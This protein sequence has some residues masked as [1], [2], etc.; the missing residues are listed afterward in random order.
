MD[1]KDRG[2]PSAPPASPRR[3]DGAR[4]PEE[5]RQRILDAARAEFSGKGLGGA[6]VNAIAERAGVN[7]QLIYYYYD[8]KERLFG[9]VLEEAYREIRAR[10]SALDL[11][12]LSPEDAMRRFIGFNFDFLVE[13]RSFVA[14]LNDENL[15]KARH[16][17]AS[18][19]ILALHE[20]LG[21]TLGRTLE[22]GLADGAFARSVAPMD[23]YILI[24][25]LCYFSLSNAY[26]LSA[27][28]ATDVTSPEKLAERRGQATEMVLCFLRTPEPPA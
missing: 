16:I 28:F 24:A 5:S 20:T 6:R 8:D 7:K 4:N 14:L 2:D 9:A 11:D 22:R 21:R 15:H 18:E 10:E 12:A 17:R 1:M 25:S 3:P 27:I 26:T 13:N 19:Q 23:L